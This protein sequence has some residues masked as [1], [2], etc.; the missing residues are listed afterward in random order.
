MMADS[1]LGATIMGGLDLDPTLP[2]IFIAIAS[3]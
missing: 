2:N 1:H 3:W